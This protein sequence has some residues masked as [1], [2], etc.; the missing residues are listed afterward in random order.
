MLQTET[1][2]MFVA[3]LVFVWFLVELTR[4]VCRARDPRLSIS[5]KDCDLLICLAGITRAL[6]LD[7]CDAIWTKIIFM[8]ARLYLLVSVF[9]RSEDRRRQY[10]IASRECTTITLVISLLLV[11]VAG[12]LSFLKRIHIQSCEQNELITEVAF[13]LAFMLS[14]LDANGLER[15]IHKDYRYST[16]LIITQIASLIGATGFIIHLPA[17]F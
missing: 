10:N 12:V 16:Q 17:S 11:S 13:N 4:I 14:L 15:K 5:R 8:G 7:D 3:L 1:A 6:P 9:A 2:F